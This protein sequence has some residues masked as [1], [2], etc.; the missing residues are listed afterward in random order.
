MFTPKEEK[1]PT[2]GA[3]HMAVPERGL[4]HGDLDFNYKPE[5]EVVK[6]EREIEDAKLS[7]HGDITFL[8]NKLKALQDLLKVS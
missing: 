6:L 5:E 2:D 7:G 1:E 8:E 3:G 4:D